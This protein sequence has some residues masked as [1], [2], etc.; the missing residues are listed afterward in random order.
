MQMHPSVASTSVSVLLYA[1]EQTRARQSWPCTTTTPY[2]PYTNTTPA[3]EEVR[4]Y[5]FPSHC[6][7]P[8]WPDNPEKMKPKAGGME[9]FHLFLV[10]QELCWIWSERTCRKN[11]KIT[12]LN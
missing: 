7:G 1:G 10:K 11:F 2:W 4:A 6:M 3:L 5:D 8:D 12:S 9:S